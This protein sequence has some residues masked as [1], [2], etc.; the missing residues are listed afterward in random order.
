VRADLI[1]QFCGEIID[2]NVV[3][4]IVLLMALMAA[5]DGSGFRRLW[6]FMA[7][8]ARLVSTKPVVE[9]VKYI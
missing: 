1:K 2:A 5:L 7:V 6:L 8:I 9:V 3:D 4:E